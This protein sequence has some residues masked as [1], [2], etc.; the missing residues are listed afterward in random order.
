LRDERGD[1][2]L[3]ECA[4][5][6]K[7]N[8]AMEAILPGLSA[9]PPQRLS[10][11]PTIGVRAFLLQRP[12]GNF[13]IYAAEPAAEERAAVEEAGGIAR[14]YLNHW[15]E[16]GT[17]CDRI[18]AAFGAPLT[19]HE[20]EA[21]RVAE[22]CPV[23][24]TFS[25]R[26]RVDEDLDVIPVPGHTAGATAYLWTG[27]GR[28]CLFTG[29][30]LYIRDG[31]WRAALLD[32][33][34]RDAYLGSLQRLRDLDFDLLVPWAA[35]LDGPYVARTDPDDA[36]RRISAVIERVRGGADG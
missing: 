32:S 27:G 8:A 22:V 2:S 14:H 17:G 11:A 6:R 30:T 29:D 34:D 25:E 24:E 4:R 9:S 7:R 19:C 16:A 35:S 15:H 3:G 10:F 36:R 23:A 21:P 12:A 33:S 13:M 5:Q 20:E 28:R 18:A 1:A 26:H 31:E